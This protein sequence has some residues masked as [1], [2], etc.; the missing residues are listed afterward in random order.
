MTQRS[1]EGNVAPGAE[2]FQV[3]DDGIGETVICAT[4]GVQ[5][6]VVSAQTCPVCADERQYLPEGGQRW[7]TPEELARRHYNTMTEEEPGLYS[8]RTAPAF[9]IGQRALLLATPHGNVLWDCLSLVDDA[10]IATI[11]SKGGLAAIAISH[12]HFY[13]AMRVWS[14]AFGG[15]PVWIHDADRQWIPDPAPEIR[16]W[17]GSTKPLPGDLTLIHVGGHFDGSQVLHWPAGAGGHGVAL[18]GDNPNVC[19]DHRWVTF[20][21]SFPNY[22]PLAAD[23]AERVV[24][25]LRPHAFD[26]LYGWTPERVIR[27]DA[28]R[29]IERSLI[30]HVRALR[31]EHGAVTWSARA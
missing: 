25:A 31:G 9:A 21:R 19:A 2:A 28:K 10:T 6:Q 12:P 29:N 13:G 3:R 8:I 23:E 17:S 22:I 15:V 4:C 18:V 24:A 11:R 26:R 27:Q 7:I 16:T 30:R 1:D 5:R 20:M 14:R